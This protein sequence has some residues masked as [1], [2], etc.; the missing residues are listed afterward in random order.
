MFATYFHFQ[1]LTNLILQM[2]QNE[3]S[4]SLYGTK[5]PRPESWDLFIS[6][7]LYFES[8][9]YDALWSAMTNACHVNDKRHHD[10][11]GP[12]RLRDALRQVF[13]VAVLTR[14]TLPQRDLGMVEREDLNRFVQGQVVD[15]EF[16]GALECVCRKGSN[17]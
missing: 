15:G 8:P 3:M 10:G 11:K 7:R 2:L 16:D 17:Q 6:M 4:V 1:A 9:G 13:R 5:W 14:D 12:D